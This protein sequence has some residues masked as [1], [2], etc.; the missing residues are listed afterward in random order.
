MSRAAVVMSQGEF[1][2]VSAEPHGFV[3]SC[4]CGLVMATGMF[5]IL[6]NDE[7]VGDNAK[8]QCF[9]CKKEQIIPLYFWTESDAAAFLAC[10]QE[11]D[12]PPIV[13]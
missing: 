4:E 8:K 12:S 1:S 5:S 11:D 3:A 7:L 10:K 13:C 9:G 2:I 6:R